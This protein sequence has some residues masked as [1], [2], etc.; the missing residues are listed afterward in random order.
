MAAFDYAQNLYDVALKPRIL[1]SLINE[2]I[3]E[4][5]QQLRNSLAFEHVVSAI[6]THQLLSERVVQSVDDK[7]TI[8][9]WKSAVDF[10]IDRVLMLVSSNMPVKCWAGICLLGVTC[11]GCSS[12]RFL[13]SYSVWLQKL[14]SHLQASAGS[15]FVKLAC[16]VSI[17]DLLTRLSGFPNM[18][19]DGSSH[20]AKLIQ[21]V[22]KLIQED[23]S[24]AEGPVNLLCT[25]LTSFPSS[26][27]KNSDSA[28]A[29]IVTKLMSGRCNTNMVKKLALCLSLLPKSRGDADSWSLMIQKVL[30]AINVLLNDSF[31]GLEEETKTMRALVPLG[32]DPPTPLGGLPIFDISNKSTRLE[33]LSMASISSL[34]LCCSTMLTTSYPAQAKVP[35]QLLLMLVERV[36]MVDGS[37]TQTLYPTITAMQQEYVCL[38]L[39]VQHSY[40]LDILCAIVKEARSQLLPHAAHIIQTVTEYL[41]KCE[42]PGLRVKLYALIKLMLLSMGVGLSLY[43]AEDVVNNASID[44]DSVGDR[45]GEAR[46]NSESMQKKRKHEM[47]VMSFENQAQTNYLPKNPVPISVK[48]AA[49]EALETLLTV[50]GAS[51]SNS[52]RSSVDSLVITV[53]TDACKGGWI[54]PANDFNNSQ[55]SS[56][57]WADFQLASLRALLASLLS[58]GRIRPPYLAH[59]LELY[60]KGKQETGTKL[61]EFCAHALMALEVLIHPRT[62]PLIDFGSSIE[63]PVSG[64]KNRFMENYTYSGAQKHNVFPGGTSRNE[65]EN[66]E[67]EDDD[68]YEK[69]VKDSDGNQPPVTEQENNETPPQLAEKVV[70]ISSGA[71]VIPEN[72]GKGILVETQSVKEANKPP[73]ILIQTVDFRASDNMVTCDPETEGKAPVSSSVG[74]MEFKFDLGDNDDPMD[75]IPDI[76]DVEPDSDEE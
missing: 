15:S 62:I 22:L 56:S 19:R 52:W 30:I 28:E 65:P 66:P 43:L 73:E 2:H 70:S 58:P 36:L 63:Y 61:A 53:A 45:G 76:V 4:E 48:I 1:R 40:C 35:I 46:S 12:E 21:P 51:G 75:E 32:K 17:S 18:K 11:E 5:K 41:R 37:L 14:L 71:E 3:P 54:K 31:Q 67:S 33:R 29:A 42:L 23:S 26:L 44:L 10:W 9:K 38:E 72:K 55:N 8:E 6:R 13:A 16:C 25:V 50:G 34:M 7:K 20:A 57:D 64:V 74:G 27:Q 49:L 59:G 69:W 68:L 60:R 39:P 24:D 47:A